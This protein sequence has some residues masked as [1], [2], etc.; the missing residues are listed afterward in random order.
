MRSHR[1]RAAAG[2]RSAFSFD[3]S[4]YGGFFTSGS[5]LNNMVRDTNKSAG[6]NAGTSKKAD[7]VY[8]NAFYDYK[9]N[10]IWVCNNLVINGNYSAG[11][12]NKTFSTTAPRVNNSNVFSPYYELGA[13]HGASVTYNALTDNSSS[14]NDYFVQNTRYSSILI[15]YLQDDTPVIVF[16]SG[17][18]S[19]K[20]HFWTHTSTPSYIGYMTTAEPL[21]TGNSNVNMTYVTFSGTQLLTVSN[22]ATGY[23]WGFDLPANTSAINGGTLVAQSRWVL[24]TNYRQVHLNTG[25]AFTG[26]GLMYPTDLYGYRTLTFDD[27]GG[28]SSQYVGGANDGSVTDVT[29]YNISVYFGGN[30][31]DYKYRNFVHPT[32][33]TFSFLSTGEAHMYES[34]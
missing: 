8:L 2:N 26:T 5:Y 24:N 3:D 19:G 34:Q 18:T 10:R 28:Y 16:C 14:G 29:S 20:I 7:P 12:V 31:I 27:D 23:V 25:I 4:A 6:T 33:G 21:S 15:A 1:L 30:N 13:T 17:N 22:D 11:W 32:T 9:F